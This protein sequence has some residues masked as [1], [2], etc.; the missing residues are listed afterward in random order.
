M[1]RRA[2]VAFPFSA[3]TGASGRRN[4][5][6]QHAAAQRRNVEG[7]KGKSGGNYPEA[8]NRQKAKDAANDEENTDDGAHATGNAAVA[9]GYGPPDGIAGLFQSMAAEIQ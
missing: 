7:D 5:S 9:P 3:R 1:R 8:D 2:F 6:S 4:R